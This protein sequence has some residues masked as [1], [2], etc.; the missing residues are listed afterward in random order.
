MLIPTLAHTFAGV[1]HPANLL[2][3][4]SDGVFISS[5]REFLGQAL[6]LASEGPRSHNICV[7]GLAIQLAGVMH[8]DPCACSRLDLLGQESAT[9]VRRWAAGLPVETSIVIDSVSPGV[10]SQ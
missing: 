8:G 7:A 2:L 3:M 1:R 10:G 4:K 6:E 9:A 5:F